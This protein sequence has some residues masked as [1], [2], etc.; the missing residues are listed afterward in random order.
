[1]QGNVTYVNVAKFRSRFS[2]IEAHHELFS[3]LDVARVADVLV[4]VA[5][6]TGNS[7]LEQTISKVQKNYTCYE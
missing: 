5:T 4:L 6:Y 3:M 2:V 7:D 1:M